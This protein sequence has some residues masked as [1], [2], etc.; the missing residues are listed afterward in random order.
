L[1]S[2]TTRRL[3]LQVPADRKKDLKLLCSKLQQRAIL[4]TGPPGLADRLDFVPSKAF[5]CPRGTRSS[6][7]TRIGHQVGFRL[8]QSRNREPPP[9]RWKVIKELV[10]A[11]T[12]F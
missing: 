3:I 1:L 11:A 6:S 2:V 12:A 5:R 4:D 10:D 7:G 8:F 9:N